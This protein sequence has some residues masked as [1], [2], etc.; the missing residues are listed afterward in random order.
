MIISLDFL[1][2]YKTTNGIEA[3][4]TSYMNGPYRVTQG[5]YSY[6]GGDGKP[7]TVHYIADQ[8]GYRAS[9]LYFSI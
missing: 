5:Y 3:R 9:G 4:Q 6:L 7:Y 1:F 8:N 2:S